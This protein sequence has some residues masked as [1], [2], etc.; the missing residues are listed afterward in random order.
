MKKYTEAKKIE[1]VD[2]E[3]TSFVELSDEQLHEVSGGKGT[4]SGSAGW[5]DQDLDGGGGGGHNAM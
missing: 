4:G 3:P 5:S 1:I 2:L